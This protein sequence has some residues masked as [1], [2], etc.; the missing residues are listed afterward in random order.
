MHLLFLVVKSV[1]ATVLLV[2][3]SAQACTAAWLE[4]QRAQCDHVTTYTWRLVGCIICMY[5]W[6]RKRKTTWKDMKEIDRLP[7]NLLHV[8]ALR[9]VSM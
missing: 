4:R 8:T 2:L 5:I 3:P 6:V 7:F 9:I 1:A